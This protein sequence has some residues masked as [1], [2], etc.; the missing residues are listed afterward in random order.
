MTTNRD[1]TPMRRL[2]RS[3]AFGG[4]IVTLAV[5]A[6][7]G[8]SPTVTTAPVASAA[9][10]STARAST[11]PAASTSAAPSTAPAA[12]TRT[13]AAA[14]TTTSAAATVTRAASP[15]TA[16]TATRGASPAAGTATRTGSPTAG[17]VTPAQAYSNL[18][19]LPSSRQSWTLS[20][21]N[22]G[23]LSGDMKPVF[24]YSGGNKRVTL[25]GVTPAVEAL[26]IGSTIYVRNPLGGYVQADSGNPL[27]APAQALFSAPD[28]ILAALI[29]AG[30]TY[31][32]AGTETV[33][34]QSA[35]RYTTTTT[36]TDLAFV[37]PALAGQGGTAATT[38]WVDNA[39]GYI[40]ALESTITPNQGGTAAKARLDVTNVGQV[41]AITAP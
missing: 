28:M 12:T 39:Q 36:L 25:A 6:A 27:A 30:G 33:N 9:P 22:I 29:P 20:G 31:T 37:N 1:G 8:A 38:I 24:E 34:G 16:A 10:A 35:T 5:L 26:Q 32:A 4:L 11:A 15:T 19:K 40:V 18:Q 2:R 14:T 13:T 21:F 7:C 17:A 3:L 41:P 23:G